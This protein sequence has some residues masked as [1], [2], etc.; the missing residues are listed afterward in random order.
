M[1]LKQARST[2][3]TIQARARSSGSSAPARWVKQRT[4]CRLCRLEL[5]RRQVRGPVLQTVAQGDRI[6]KNSRHHL[7]TVGA[8]MRASLLHARRCGGKRGIRHG[9]ARDAAAKIL[10]RAQSVETVTISPKSQSA[11]PSLTMSGYDLQ[12]KIDE[13]DSEGLPTQF[14]VNWPAMLNGRVHYASGKPM[15]AHQSHPAPTCRI[16]LAWWVRWHG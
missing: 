10:S 2:S 8:S 4:K 5:R 1:W 7:E 3:L 14:Q 9:Q 11:E 6:L 16:S 12:C 13:R 15:S